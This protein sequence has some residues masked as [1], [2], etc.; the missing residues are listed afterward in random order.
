MKKNCIIVLATL[1]F[2]TH[3]AKS[4]MPPGVITNPD[5]FSTTDSARILPKKSAATEN[6]MRAV[7]LITATIGFGAAFQDARYAAGVFTDGLRPAQY[8]R[9]CNSW[10]IANNRAIRHATDLAIT[11]GCLIG[12]G[13][14]LESFWRGY[15][16][17]KA[18]SEQKQ[19]RRAQIISSLITSGC[20]FITAA[21]GTWAFELEHR[22]LTL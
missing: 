21:V 1:L 22:A 14:L 13:K 9:V 10:F 7:P 18:S 15:Q 16:Y 8:D 3:A 12:V 4:H 11:A 20:G 5:L 19:Q 6:L 17:L 2:A